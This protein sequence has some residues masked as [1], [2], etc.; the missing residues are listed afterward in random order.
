M[1]VVYYNIFGMGHINP[2]LPI[3]KKLKE[4]GAEILYYTSPIRKKNVESAGAFFRNYGSDDYKAENY[5]PGKNFILQLLPATVGILPYLCQE[6]EKFQPDLILYDSMAPWGYCLSQIYQIPSVCTVTTFAFSPQKRQQMYDFYKIEI[7]DVSKNAIEFLETE[8]NISLELI[9]ALGS[10][11]RCNLVFT[12]K[13]FNPSLGMMKEDH[14]HFVGPMMEER[15]KVDFPLEKIQ[16]S[17]K[18]II[19]MSLGTVV[20]NED[21]TLI[22]VFKTAIE[23]IRQDERF[24]LVMSIS[25]G[26]KIEDFDNIPQNVLIYNFVPQ[27]EILKIAEIFIHHSGMNSINEGL[28]FGKP[29][30]TIPIAHEQFAN[31]ARI[32]ELKLGI[33]LSR[34]NLTSSM[35]HE[36]ITSVLEN[37][38]YRQNCSEISKDFKNCLGHNEAMKIILDAM[39]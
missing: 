15:A 9:H 7:D 36:A 16:N 20:V 25:R 8:H 6:L 12:S 30:I 27:L 14:F 28:F 18:K 11:N 38:L 37:P 5:N 3:V 2:T 22:E 19:Y 23:A 13:K 33:E 31:A 34:K 4:N 10:Y 21:P 29:S 1:K 24:L 17:G 26:L 32:S 35:I 39:S